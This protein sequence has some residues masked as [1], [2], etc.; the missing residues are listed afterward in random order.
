MWLLP[1]QQSSTDLIHYNNSSFCFF[2]SSRSS[3][4]RFSASSWKSFPLRLLILPAFIFISGGQPYMDRKQS[5]APPSLRPESWSLR[6]PLSGRRP[7]EEEEE[8]EEEQRS[9]LCL[10]CF[11]FGEHRPVIKSLR[12]RVTF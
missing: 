12:G 3:C 11:I 8:E 4:T 1:R 5:E 10:R 2:R 6:R 7:E 9:P